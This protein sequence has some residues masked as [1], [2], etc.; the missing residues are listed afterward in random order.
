[1]QKYYLNKKINSKIN[2]KNLLII[3]FK[4]AKAIDNLIN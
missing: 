3:E 2:N 1:M 4:V